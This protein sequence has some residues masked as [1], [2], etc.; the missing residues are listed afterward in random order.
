MSV[1]LQVNIKA[2]GNLMKTANMTIDKVT[3][4]AYANPRVKLSGA[5]VNYI[6][7][8]VVHTVMISA[9]SGLVAGDVLKIIIQT[10]GDVSDGSVFM[11]LNEIVY[12]NGTE[13][14]WAFII[15][16]QWVGDVIVSSHLV[17]HGNKSLGTIY[18]SLK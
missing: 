15:P 17:N 2:N 6:T 16:A 14:A 13:L 9:S 7:K 10:T 18:Y 5:Y 1:L 3:R 8:G 4:G 11:E 12:S